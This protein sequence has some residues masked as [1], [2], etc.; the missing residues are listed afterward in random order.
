VW[1]A[2]LATEPTP[3]AP[4]DRLEALR[5]FINTRTAQG[6]APPES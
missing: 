5:A 4:P 2:I 3:A 6:G 1:E